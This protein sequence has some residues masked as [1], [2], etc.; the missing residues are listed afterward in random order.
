MI[1]IIVYCAICVNCKA[2]GVGSTFDWKPRLANYK[3]HINKNIQTCGIV[4]HFLHKCV[5]AEDPLSNLVFVIIDGLNNTENLTKEEI[6]DLL[7]EK[8]KFWIGNLVTQHAGMNCSHDWNRKTR[9]EKA[10]KD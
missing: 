6:D 5:D 9:C 2:Q 8:E 10:P 7:L 3:S 4:K 1:I